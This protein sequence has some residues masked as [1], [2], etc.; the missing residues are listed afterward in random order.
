MAV[1]PEQFDKFI[2]SKGVSLTCPQCGA[3][4]HTLVV[5]TGEQRPAIVVFPK[6]DGFSITE[7]KPYEVVLLQCKNCGH[8]RTFARDVVEGWAKPQSSGQ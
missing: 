3:T 2:K 8:V 1:T 6:G 5:E 7:A 4:P